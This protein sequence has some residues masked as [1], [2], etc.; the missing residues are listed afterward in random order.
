MRNEEGVILISPGMKGKVST[1]SENLL[2]HAARKAGL[3]IDAGPWVVVEFKNRFMVASR[4]G[5]EREKSSPFPTLRFWP[6]QCSPSCF[7]TSANPA[8]LERCPLFTS[9]VL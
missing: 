7:D 1:R 3:P 8:G 2:A 4:T 5:S 9:A 6:V